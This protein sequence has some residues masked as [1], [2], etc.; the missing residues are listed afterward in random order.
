[1][2]SDQEAFG[3]LLRR[4]ESA[5]QRLEKFAQNL[6]S[7]P[8]TT[9]RPET[10]AAVEPAP[11]AAGTTKPASPASAPQALPASVTAY[12]EFL[13]QEVCKYLDFSAQLGGPVAEQANLIGR[14]AQLERG[15]IL[16]A[17]QSRKPSNMGE[18]AES[19]K[20]LVECI[21][22][23]DDV[24]S[25][26]RA[27]KFMFERLTA[28]SEGAGAFGWV[29][30]EP[31]PVPYV[32]DMRDSAEFYVNRVK[33]KVKAA[34][35][36]GDAAAIGEWVKSYDA[37]LKAL[38]RYVEA[39]HKTGLTWNPQGCEFK[40]YTGEDT[41]PA[42]TAQSAGGP[43]PPPPPPPAPVAPPPPP[44]VAPTASSGTAAPVDMTSVL[45]DL[46]KGEAI[47]QGLRKVDRSQMTHKNPA[48]RSKSP[49]QSRQAGK[50]KPA[51]PIPTKPRSLTK[52]VPPK[53]QL[54]GNKWVVENYESG[55]LTI[56][57]TDMRQF[58]YIYNC[59]NLTVQVVGKLNAVTMDKCKKVGMV[60]DTVIST[61]DIVNSASLQFQIT[62][63]CPA[64]LLDKVDGALVFLG[65]ECHDIEITTSKTSEINISMKGE[66]AGDDED[67]KEHPV[68]EQLRTVVKN[69][70][71]V[72]VPVEHVG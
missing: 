17:S 48:L 20:P 71:L 64:L 32:K 66:G 27:D 45:K 61:V 39:Y 53:F 26:H 4:L 54:E 11:V 47:T 19:L 2:S 67:Y 60:V 8:S 9:G 65:S 69:G 36:D 49:V 42:A 24:R 57:I 30:V 34:A 52:K 63:R 29:T 51:P 37:M 43:P 15:V 5:T 6:S 38:T 18:F 33:T 50:G 1:M 72:T 44:Q 46:N 21:T 35:G 10:L 68:P 3:S 7:D 70:R 40:D 23:A 16:R 56:E 41:K 14:L 28:V 58:V 59:Q 22:G 12:D 25:K 13:T 62:G 31:T 55:Q